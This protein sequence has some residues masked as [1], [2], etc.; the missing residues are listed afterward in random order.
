M[1]TLWGFKS[2]RPN[3][4]QLWVLPSSMMFAIT[5]PSLDCI[6]YWPIV[7]TMKSE[8]PT[9]LEGQSIYWESYRNHQQ[10]LQTA[11]RCLVNLGEWVSLLIYFI[12]VVNFARVLGRSRTVLGPCNHQGWW[13]QDGP[14]LGFLWYT[15]P[16]LF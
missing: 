15:T 6:S 13:S 10:R 2:H 4:A 5:K 1:D 7:S 8:R 9:D 12:F 11:L 14:Q 3:V 16:K